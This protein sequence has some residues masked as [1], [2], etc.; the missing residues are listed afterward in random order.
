[1]DVCIHQLIFLCKFVRVWVTWDLWKT[2]L[3]RKWNEDTHT[4][5]FECRMSQLDTT[6]FK[7]NQCGHYRQTNRHIDT[8]MIKNWYFK[9]ISPES[10]RLFPVALGSAQRE[11][12]A[13]TH[14]GHLAGASEWTSPLTSL[15]TISTYVESAL[16][17]RVRLD[18]PHNIFPTSDI[19]SHHR[20]ASLYVFFFSDFITALQCV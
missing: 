9:H 1:M 18:P 8:S 10:P 15:D 6:A 17:H 5:D 14:T 13:A 7:T 20:W 2:L 3:Y 19:E 4:F 11:Q 16:K 12:D